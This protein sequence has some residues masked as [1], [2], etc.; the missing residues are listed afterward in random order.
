[1][2]PNIQKLQP[3]NMELKIKLILDQSS[4]E[5]WNRKKNNL[6]NFPKQVQQKTTNKKNWDNPG[7]FNLNEK[8]YR[9]QK[10]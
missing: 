9:K 6:N 2:K 5:R 3:W 10:K 7:H 4:V 1:M 8:I